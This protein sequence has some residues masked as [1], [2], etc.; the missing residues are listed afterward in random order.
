MGQAAD[1]K[2]G[3]RE[4]TKQRLVLSFNMVLW[5]ALTT[6]HEARAWFSLDEGG[7]THKKGIGV[8]IRHRTKKVLRGDSAF[9]TF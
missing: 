2:D 7:D 9:D 8:V 4:M 6:M 5:F 1:G 3:G